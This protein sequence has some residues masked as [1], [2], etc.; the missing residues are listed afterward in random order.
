MNDWAIYSAIPSFMYNFV[1]MNYINHLGK[2]FILM[3]QVFR[4]P[5]RMRIF[6]IQLLKEID[7][8]G[9]GSLGIAA[10]ITTFMGAVVTL[11][12]AA[13]IDSPIIP[14]YAVGYATRE[15]VI[16]EFSSTIACLILAGKVGSSI[17]SQ[18]G[19]MRVTEQIDAL[20]IMGI[21]S[22][23]YLVLPKIMA[24]ILIFPFIVSICMI[25]GIAGGWLSGE[26]TGEVPTDQYMEGILYRFKPFNVYYSL[27]KSVFFGFIITSISAY[28]GY[29]TKGG[30]LEVGQSSTKGV[31]YSSVAILVF[32]YV[33]TQ[34]LLL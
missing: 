28:H 6:G 21:N 20:E 15:S 2:Y 33:I 9:I 8:I 17:A 30:A 4:K 23:N 32:N 25:M 1:T 16:L 34:L 18:I 14:G 3:I 12:T 5:Q 19:T 31:V 13:N 11:Q 10:I 24:S 27:I 26:F 22:A 7:S 29:Y